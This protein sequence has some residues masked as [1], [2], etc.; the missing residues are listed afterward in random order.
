MHIF[1]TAAREYNGRKIF[2]LPQNRGD[3]S[4]VKPSRFSFMIGGWCVIFIVRVRK[5]GIRKRESEKKNNSN[6]KR[7]NYWCYRSRWD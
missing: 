5:E 4:G 7:Q 2:D 6:E 1:K 3:A